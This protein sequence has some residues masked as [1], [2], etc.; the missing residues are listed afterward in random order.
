[1]KV[2]LFD[3]L[4]FSLNPQK[5]LLIDGF[6]GAPFKSGPAHREIE[7]VIKSLRDTGIPPLLI[8][9]SAVHTIGYT[10]MSEITNL[11]AFFFQDFSPL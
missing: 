4:P 5:K 6:E 9:P 2:D 11:L 8:K 1:M 7:D 3:W 10:I